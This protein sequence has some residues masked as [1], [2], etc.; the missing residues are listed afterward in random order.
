MTAQ[1]IA[2]WVSLDKAAISRAVQQLLKRGLVQR[3]LHSVD[4]R[5]VEIS[6]TAR[7]LRVY[8]AIAHRTAALQAEL[9]R[10]IAAEDREALF[11]VL[12]RIEATL[13]APDPAA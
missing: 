5:T 7:G 10:D 9:L 2:H 12:R 4:A 13:R 11:G 6:M 3:R 1:T 8:A